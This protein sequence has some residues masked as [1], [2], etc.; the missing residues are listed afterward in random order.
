MDHILFKFFT[1]TVFKMTI[2]KSEISDH[3][4][5]SMVP[6]STKQRSNTKNTILYKQVFYTEST[7]LLKQKLYETSWDDT[8]VSQN[9]NEAYKSFKK[10]FSDLYNAYFLKQQIK[11]KSKDL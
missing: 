5:C 7:K 10:I 2:S 6:S 4:L 1:D 8:E 3:F 11:L 9:P